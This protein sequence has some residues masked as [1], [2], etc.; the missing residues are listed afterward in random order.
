[1]R[2]ISGSLRGKK[3][4]GIRGMAIRPTSDRVRESIF[5]IISFHVRD[6]L[7]LDMFA[8]TGALGIEAL[9]R[10]AAS[11]VFVDKYHGALSVIERNIRS[12]A[13]GDRAKIIRWDIRKRLSPLI[14]SESRFDLV[15]MDPPYNKNLIEPALHKLHISHILKKDARVIVEHSPSEP[16]PKELAV[17]DKAPNSEGS[18]QVPFTIT[19]QRKYGKTLASFLDYML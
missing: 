8:G 12:C 9:S 7:V 19:D 18:V 3:L 6:A 16:I 14:A 17:P 2:I 15:F 4:H 11:A 10:G 13:L 5:N 1:M